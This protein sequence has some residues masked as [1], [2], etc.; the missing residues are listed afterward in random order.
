M[1]WSAMIPITDITMLDYDKGKEITAWAK[2]MKLQHGLSM[3]VLAFM[4]AFDQLPRSREVL[5]RPQD[6]DLARKLME[7]E[8]IKEMFPA[9]ERFAAN[10]SLENLTEFVDGAIDSIYVILWTLL[11]LN[12]PVNEC[13]REVQRSNMAKLNAAGSYT[14]TEAGKV[15]KPATWTAPDLFG[16]LQAHYDFAVYNGNIRTG[17]KEDL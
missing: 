16:I 14:K 9:F 8:C 15:Q 5:A 17:D 3:D 12:V 1:S 11:K 2:A 10:Q 7:E 6:L 4:I 13:W